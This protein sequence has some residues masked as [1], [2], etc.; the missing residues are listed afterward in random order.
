MSETLKKYLPL[1]GAVIVGALLRSGI[2]IA[3]FSDMM[4]FRRP[5]T[6]LYLEMAHNLA[7]YGN[8]GNLTGRVPLF[9]VLCAGFIFL[10][11]TF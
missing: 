10:R 2:T 4:R 9:P 8:F 7:E 11:L 3:A 6:A 1:A 5:D